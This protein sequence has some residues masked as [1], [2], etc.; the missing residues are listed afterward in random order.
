[1]RAGRARFTS[2]E[3]ISLLPIASNNRAIVEGAMHGKALNPISFS[4]WL[5]DRLLDA[6]IDGLVLRSAN[7]RKKQACF[8]IKAR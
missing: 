6:P 8:W 5:K 3:I 4:K 2:S 7:D 1:M